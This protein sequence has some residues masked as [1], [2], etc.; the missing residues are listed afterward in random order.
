MAIVIF[1]A[2]A[3]YSVSDENLGRA[4]KNLLPAVGVGALGAACLVPDWKPDP[5]PG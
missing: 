3:C 2:A 1:R 5:A 4:P